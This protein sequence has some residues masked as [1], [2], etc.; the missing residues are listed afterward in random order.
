MKN[1]LKLNVK[2]KNIQIADQ[3]IIDESAG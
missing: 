1:Y 2:E 3:A